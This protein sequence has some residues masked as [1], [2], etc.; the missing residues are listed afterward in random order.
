M[1]KPDAKLLTKAGIDL[2]KIAYP[3]YEKYAKLQDAGNKGN[4]PPCK[5]IASRAQS[6]KD[7]AFQLIPDAKAKA[8]IL[9]FNKGKD[10]LGN[11]A[12]KLIARSAMESGEGFEGFKAEIINRFAIALKS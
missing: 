12:L 10:E 3:L 2:L 6:I 5:P 4:L 1:S 8:K 7:N 9:A 11:S